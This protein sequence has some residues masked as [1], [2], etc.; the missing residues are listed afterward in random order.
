MISDGVGGRCERGQGWVKL[1]RHQTLS[2]LGERCCWEIGRGEETNWKLVVAVG[3][4]GW[5]GGGW[6][7]IFGSVLWSGMSLKV[8][9]FVFLS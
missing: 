4:V 6:S 2:C 8:F 9:L 5:V 7:Y 1:A 3:E